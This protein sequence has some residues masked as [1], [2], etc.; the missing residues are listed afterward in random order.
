MRRLKRLI[1]G[2]EG[3]VVQAC[4][5]TIIIVMGTI[6]WD[7]A[8]LPMALY[9]DTIEA[10]DVPK[11][12]QLASIINAN[13]VVAGLVEVIIVVGPLAWLYASCFRK[14]RQAYPIDSYY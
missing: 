2:E 12:P 1:K 9:T 14:E 3:L 6:L 7:V 4:V 13:V 8:I 5:A 11:P 10:L